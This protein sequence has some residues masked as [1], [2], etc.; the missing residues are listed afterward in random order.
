M[1]RYLCLLLIV[2][3]T[4][5]LVLVSCSPETKTE[6]KK[7]ETYTDKNATDVAT[8]VGTAG[9]SIANA[10]NTLALNTQPCTLTVDIKSTT[11]KNMSLGSTETVAAGSSNLSFREVTSSSSSGYQEIKLT[12]DIG[13]ATT[14]GLNQIATKLAS[15]S[16]YETFKR[17]ATE[18]GKKLADSELY[19]EFKN[20]FTNNELSFRGS[21]LTKILTEVKD[22]APEV[23]VEILVGENGANGKLTV[24]AGVSGSGNDIK[25]TVTSAVLKDKNGKIIMS[26][27]GAVFSVAFD[28]DFDVILKIENDAIKFSSVNGGVTVSVDKMDVKTNYLLLSKTYGVAGSIKWNFSTKKLESA[29]TVK[30]G[31]LDAGFSVKAEL[32]DK[33]SAVSSLVNGL[34]V[35]KLSY[36]GTDFDTD[37]VNTV[38]KTRREIIIT[39]L[40]SY[41]DGSALKTISASTSK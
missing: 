17:E 14:K 27:E 34:E 37:S 12:Y 28:D 18:E 4:L 30:G 11:D 35:T 13:A 2:L 6:E 41:L 24:T 1:K 21:L 5:S 39:A 3:M 38:L 36:D 16:D 40:K 8:D 23:T 7:E 15:G 22:C 9:L 29:L 20:L 26:T 19:K 31:K 33:N 10:V 32:K 25:V